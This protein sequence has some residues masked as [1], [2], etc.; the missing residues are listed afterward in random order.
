MPRQAREKSETG[1]YHVM[2]KG[3][4]G[5][6]IFLDDDDRKWFLL[7]LFKAKEKAGFEL[8]GYC[9]MDNH[10]H[11]LLKENEGLGV[12]IKRI[13][14]G[15]VQWHNNKYGRAGHLFLNRFNSEVVETDEYFVTVLRYIHLN[16][17]KARIVIQAKD[18]YWSSY[19]EYL[20][21]YQ[22]NR[23]RAEMDLKV[24]ELFFRNLNEFEKFMNEN[25]SDECLEYSPVKKYTDADL[26]D[27]IN[28]Y[29]HGS[30]IGNMS[31]EE[32]TKMAIFIYNEIES[33]SI[34]QLARILGIGK[35]CVERAL[36][37]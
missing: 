18:Y 21:Y 2:L 20:S 22:N 16:P 29:T 9:L 28:T 4:D 35:N 36:K 12:S 26:I 30:G 3:I 6:N 19:R 37:K 32:K 25:N 15:Y 1:I 17:V 23:S 24:I 14:V 10:V 27:V 11:L 33:V 34:R 13:T 31:P 8:Y 7:R 5:R